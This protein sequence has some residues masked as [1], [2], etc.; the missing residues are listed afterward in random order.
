MPDTVVE[1]ACENETAAAPSGPLLLV[2]EDSVIDQCIVRSLVR[3]MSWNAV[4]ASDGA[5]AL[6]MLA[7]RRPDLILTDLQMPRLDGLEL[8]E[9]VREQY[10]EIPVILMTAFGSE[11]I[12][13]E[14]LRRG[15]ASYVAKRFLKR[16]LPET[17]ERVLVN[18]KSQRC[19]LQLRSCVTAVELR[20]EL[21][22]DPA[23]VPALVRHVQEHLSVLHLCS[24]NS[25]LRVGVALEEALL[26]GLYHGN[27]GLSS[28]LRQADGEQ[29]FRDLAEERRSLPPYADRRLYIKA[30][31]NKDEAVFTIHDE[32]PGFDVATLPDPTDP[33]NLERVGGRGVLLMRTF[34]DEVSFNS[35]GNEVTLIKRREAERAR[36]K[37]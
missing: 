16:E 5:E 37:L 31:L 18:A 4:Y 20:F 26:N 13:L 7:V 1:T 22:N 25:A 17:L 24:S 32:G 6:E 11:T 28:D 35:S 21:A 30:S 2:V 23:L 3:D 33:L 29:A 36:Q 19:D 12:A 15:A 34:M 10:P 9:A 14:A 27:L 8:V